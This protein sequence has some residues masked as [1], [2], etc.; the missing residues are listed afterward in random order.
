[1]AAASRWL[2]WSAAAL[3]IAAAWTS[4][5]THAALW[6]WVDSNGRTVY[7]DIAPTGD[8]KAERVNGPAPRANANAAKEMLNQEAELKKRQMQRAE[9]E[10]KA[11]K[12]KVDT[13]KRQEQCTI[14][15]GQLKGMQLTNV[16]HFRINEKGERIFLDEAARKQQVERIEQYLKDHCQEK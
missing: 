9:E 2:P 6:K 14:M 8:V 10:S 4:F 16:Q 1:M 5:P 12:A 13:A 3:M 11:E 7:S 15:R